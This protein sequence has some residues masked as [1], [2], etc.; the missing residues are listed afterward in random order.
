MNPVEVKKRQEQRKEAQAQARKELRNQLKEI[1]ADIRKEFYAF[2]KFARE[3]FPEQM[4]GRNGCYVHIPLKTNKGELCYTT[5]LGIV[6]KEKREKYSFLSQE[7]PTR[8]GR[9]YTSYES[10]YPE[11]SFYVRGNLVSWGK[12][13]GAI[14]TA[15]QEISCSGFPEVIDECF[16]IWLAVRFYG[17]NVGD[18]QKLFSKRKS[19]AT[20]IVTTVN[21]FKPLDK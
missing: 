21:Y 14:R 20:E 17:N 13:G 6:P 15:Y 18:I 9:L 4:E 3:N 12:W 10:R 8:L 19:L 16:C 1:R 2:L 7:K 5:M 11:F